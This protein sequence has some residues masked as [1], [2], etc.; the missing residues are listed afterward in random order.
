MSNPILRLL[1]KRVMRG[2]TLLCALTI[3]TFA[4]LELSPIDPV[5]AYVG[6]NTTVGI[7]QRLIIASS[8][9]MDLP[10]LERF[11]QWSVGVIRG[12]WGDSMIFR[13]PVLDVIG[14]KFKSSILLMS[15]AWLSSGGLGFAFGV[16][17]GLKSGKWQDKLIQIYCQF[18]LSTP[19][20][21]IG[22]MA[23]VIFSVKLGWLPVAM[24]VPIGKL[25]SEVTLIEK[26]QHLI[27]PVVT[28]SIL[29]TAN[30]CMHTREKVI[31]I[32]ASDYVLFAR[33][34]GE[35][36]TE[37]IRNHVLRNAA[38]PAITLQCLGISELFGGAIFI[39]QVFAYPGLGQTIV[40]AGLRGDFPLLM[41][42]V[43]F[44]L[45]FVLVG[46]L[47]A[48]LLYFLVD[49]RIKKGVA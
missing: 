5:T 29:G 6:T 49:P 28:L 47:A 43:I 46:S 23:I 38:L 18:L 21:W 15:L 1:A 16:I 44:S 4:L 11:Y 24:G 41:G 25:A 19:S 22:M 34:R 14:E 20:F 3:L 17:A 30:I 7:E 13:R 45:C 39:E 32:L 42:L 26:A 10:P 40:Q 2:F 8:W 9:G 12:D 31:E 37:I 27:L 35:K 33:A 48:D 36:S